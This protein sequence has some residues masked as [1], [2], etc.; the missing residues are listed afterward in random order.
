MALCSTRGP[1]A[2]PGVR[3]TSLPGF[4]SME[5]L[6]S[7]SLGSPGCGLAATGYQAFHSIQEPEPGVAKPVG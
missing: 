6:Y 7:T 1:L 4:W 2:R 5:G 3:E